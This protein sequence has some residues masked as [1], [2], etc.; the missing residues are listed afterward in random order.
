MLQFHIH[1]DDIHVNGQKTRGE[2][3]CGGFPFIIRQ[4]NRSTIDMACSWGA[5]TLLNDYISH[6]KL[7]WITHQQTQ[8]KFTTS[9]F[10]L[11]IIISASK[12]KHCR[13]AYSLNNMF[14]C[15]MVNNSDRYTNEYSLAHM[16]NNA[17]SKRKM[18]S[19]K[20]LWCELKILQFLLFFSRTET[21]IRLKKRRI[22]ARD[23]KE[24]TFHD[25]VSINL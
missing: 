2:C 12:F 15:Y 21:W 18:F 19:V 25:N 16:N 5:W 22:D 20:E 1:I 24:P 7:A 14:I 23:T 4:Q 6:P 10:S 17:N 3:G 13:Q 11:I 9:S 8:L